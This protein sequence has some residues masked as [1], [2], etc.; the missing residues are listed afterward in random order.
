MSELKE[1]WRSLHGLTLAQSEVFQRASGAGFDTAGLAR[2]SEIFDRQAS[3]LLL[4]PME[5]YRRERPQQRSLR[6]F[7]D[8]DRAMEG[9]IRGLP[10][11][12][13]I[14]G[15]KWIEIVGASGMTAVSVLLRRASLSDSTFCMVFTGLAPAGKTPKAASC[16]RSQTPAW[17]W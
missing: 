4:Y 10:D 14:S 3:Q 13:S 17:I 2:L 5:K 9:I 7:D 11:A 8:W 15:P 12:V 16:T 1:S 6:A